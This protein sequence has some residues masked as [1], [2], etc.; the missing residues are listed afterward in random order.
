M[1][2]INDIFDGRFGKN[3]FV[4][5]EEFLSGEEVS[6]FAIS[7]GEN[8]LPLMGAQ[9]HK[10]L[11]DGD[12]GPNTGGM[13]AYCP[14]PI[15]T[16]KLENKIINQILEP[17]LSGLKKR[18][19]SYTG[20]L[21]AGLMIK[22]DEPSLIEY[23]IRFGDP[24]TQALLMLLKSSFT[25]LVLD[26]VNINLKNHKIE[27]YDKKSLTIVLA[28]KGYPLSY[29]IDSS[30]TGIEDA[31]INKNIKVFHAGTSIINGDLV[32]TGGRV[33][34]VTST[35]NTIQEARDQAYEAVEKI[36]YKDK[37]YRKDIAWRGVKSE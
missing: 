35:A 34:N 2:A 30:I 29:N 15:L 6:Y 8:I 23:N 36:K 32:A 28:N 25:E 13:G 7:D 14:P 26:T 4:L 31:E 17:T 18:G 20:V 3:Q 12:K 22:D 21:F 1:P 27:W 19:I 9:D 24:E 10:R 16:K 33:L 5:I 11:L 37:F